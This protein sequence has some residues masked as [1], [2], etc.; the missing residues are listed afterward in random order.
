MSKYDW[1]CVIEDYKRLGSH[2]AVA[3]LY[4]CSSSRVSQVLAKHGIQ[5]HYNELY[6]K[7]NKTNK[8]RSL[9]F[10]NHER[11]YGVWKTI[12]HR[13]YNP[14]REKYMNYGGRGITVASE[15]HEFESFAKWS[16]CHGYEPGLQIDRIDN[17]GS[18]SVA[19]CRFVTPKAN[20]RNRRNTKHLTLNG[21]TKSV[22][23]WCEVIET[24]SFTIYWWIRTKGQA[25]AE[26]RL[27]A[28]WKEGVRGA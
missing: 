14:K 21:V 25:Y 2:S 23:E 19:N 1:S 28:I 27:T 17:N 4:G 9:K 11:L 7:R 8:Q 22:A 13:C 12:M 20:S 18:Y 16:L 10:P 24:S 5:A 26:K 15:W 6:G 3:M